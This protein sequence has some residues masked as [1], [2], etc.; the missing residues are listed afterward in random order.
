MI[1]R[2]INKCMPNMDKTGPQGKGPRT[3]RGFGKCNSD[4]KDLLRPRGRGYGRGIG[5]GFGQDAKTD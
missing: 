1:L 5:R 4:S 3:G 2:N